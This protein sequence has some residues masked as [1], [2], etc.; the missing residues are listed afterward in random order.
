METFESFQKMGGQNTAWVGRLLG[1]QYG[2]Q[3]I[4]NAF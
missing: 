3:K 2:L 1:Y 4:R